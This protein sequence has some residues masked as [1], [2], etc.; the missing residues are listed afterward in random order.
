VAR[1]KAAR[2]KRMRMMMMKAVTQMGMLLKKKTAGSHLLMKL[3][4]RCSR[5]LRRNHRI[6]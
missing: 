5:K 3:T 2:N 1:N 6:N 4:R